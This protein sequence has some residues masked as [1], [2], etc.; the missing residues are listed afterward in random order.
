MNAIYHQGELTVQALAGV[1]E[2]A[3]RIGKSIGST[4]PAA[5]QDFLCRQPLAVVSTIDRKQ[6]VWASPLTGRPG[7]MRVIDEQNLQITAFPTVADPLYENLKFN[8]QIG[9]LVIEPATRRRMRLNGAAALLADGSLHIKAA[10]VYAN[11][12][13][14][15]Q[16]REWEFR[17]EQT[18]LD[19]SSERRSRLSGAQQQWIEKADTLFIA[20]R[21]SEGGA[22]ASHRG[23]DPGFVQVVSDELL[24]LPDYAGNKMFQTLGNL[25]TNPQAGLLFI[26]FETGST[27]QLTGAARIIWDPAR[28]QERAGAERL[29]E[30][31]IEEVL[32]TTKALPLRW[33][34]M[35][36]SPFNPK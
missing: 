3:S 28:V 24:V 35:N 7:F 14:Y 1:Q 16:A 11:C 18:I 20:S 2:L 34:F 15:I 23:G 6:R 36:Y 19:Q 29:V 21:H 9:V 4:I 5:A 26:D 32:E 8:H 13:K 10:Q 12:P 30:F 33:E 25:L 17:D 22:D 27:L 31:E